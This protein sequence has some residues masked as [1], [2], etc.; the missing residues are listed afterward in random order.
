M[1]THGWYRHLPAEERSWV[2]LVA[3]EGIAQFIAWFRNEGHVT[4]SAGSI[5]E[6]SPQ[7]LTR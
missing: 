5:F 6:F 4:P 7:E 1:E 3:Q 2:G